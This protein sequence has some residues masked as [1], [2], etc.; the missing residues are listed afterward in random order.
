[1]QIA[2]FP[3]AAPPRLHAPQWAFEPWITGP[4]AGGVDLAL[5]DTR[6][7]AAALAWTGRGVCALW[8]GEDH[9]LVCAQVLTFFPEARVVGPDSRHRAAAAALEDP[10]LASTVPVDP[11]GSSFQQHV[12]AV[13]RQ[14]PPGAQVTYGQIA[15]VLD[16]PGAARAVGAAC[17]ANRV[18]GL[19]PCHRVIRTDGS[20]GGFRWGIARKQALLAREASRRG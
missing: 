8:I 12:W 18:A 19:I 6:F 17:G 14:V 15:A 2:L 16:D 13:L 7:G 1:M 10:A 11:L 4:A 20:L 9:A 3:E 5:L